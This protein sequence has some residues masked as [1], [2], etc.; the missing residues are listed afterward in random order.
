MQYYKRIGTENQF[1]V[2]AYI[3]LAN[4]ELKRGNY[5]K[6]FK[7]CDQAISRLSANIPR[8]SRDLNKA[9]C[10][11]GNIYLD[12]GQIEEAKSVFE[13]V[14]DDAYASLANISCKYEISTQFRDEQLKQSKF[15]PPHLI[16]LEN[17]LKQILF[18]LQSL[19]EK[20]KDNYF[21]ANLIGVALAERGFLKPAKEIFKKCL[22]HITS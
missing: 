1:Y 14:K 20:I 13:G 10:F 5:P 22:E 8:K 9:K 7:I 2:D 12:C 4:L 3:R 17:Y 16:P 19:Q 21:T 6:A 15:H 11:K 18:E